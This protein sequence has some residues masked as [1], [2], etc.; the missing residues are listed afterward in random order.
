MPVLRHV[1]EDPNIADRHL[2]LTATV[3]M[4]RTTVHPYASETAGSWT[5]PLGSSR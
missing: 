2:V 1:S 4:T 5:S 3:R